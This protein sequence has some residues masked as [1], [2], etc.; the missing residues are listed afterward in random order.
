MRACERER[1]REGERVNESVRVREGEGGKNVRWI[2]GMRCQGLGLLS[3]RAFIKAR[4]EPS[5]KVSPN[6]L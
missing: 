4:F 3:N 5:S 2:G 6:S 1:E